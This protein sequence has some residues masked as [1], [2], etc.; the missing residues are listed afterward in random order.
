MLIYI[1]KKIDSSP[2]YNKEFFKTKIRSH[3]DEVTDFTINKQLRCILIILDS[4][5][6]WKL[7]LTSLFERV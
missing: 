1:Y 7:L 2:V 6:R 4:G 3:G 5:K